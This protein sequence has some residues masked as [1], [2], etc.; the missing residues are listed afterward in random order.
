MGADAGAA[1]TFTSMGSQM[2]GGMSSY[3]AAQDQADMERS[4][5]ELQKAEAYREA[6]RIESEGNRFAQAQKM[7]Y[8]GSGVQFGGSATV[9]IAQT[10]KWAKAEADAMRSRGEAMKAYGYRSAD[11]M[12]NRGFA[13]LM[14]GL[15]GAGS[16]AFAYMHA[17]K[18]V[19][20]P[21]Q[22]GKP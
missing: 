17:G 12:E 13:A 1:M 16:T 3:Q 19:L 20:Q 7:A 2:L 15:L 8:I 11:I 22:T 21:T 18:P 14:G 4:Y 10:K 9:T 5:A 6:K